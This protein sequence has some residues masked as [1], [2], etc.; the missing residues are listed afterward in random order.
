[1]LKKMLAVMVLALGAL[2]GVACASDVGEACD[3]AGAEDEC[4]DGAICVQAISGQDPTCLVTC[5]DDAQCASTEACN[6][7][8]GSNIKA[9][10][11]K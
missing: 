4:V 2:M 7:V 5:T 8:E 3:T 6:G 10:R 9:C 11:P 1:M